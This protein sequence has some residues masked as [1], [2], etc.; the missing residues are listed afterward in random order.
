MKRLA[1]IILGLMIVSLAPVLCQVDPRDKAVLTYQQR[2]FDEAMRLIDKQIAD[3]P[4]DAGLYLNKAV[5][6]RL[7]A[8]QNNQANNPLGDKYFRQ[9]LDLL[10]KARHLNKNDKE[11]KDQINGNFATTYMD[12]GNPAK[13][14]EF[15]EIVYKSS[16]RAFYRIRTACCYAE[17]GA[18]EKAL[19]LIKP[20]T[21]EQIVKGDSRGNE[22][23]SLYNMACIYTLANNPKMAVF[24][25][26]FALQMNRDR[27]Y[28]GL[29]DEAD[30]AKI[31]NSP[32]FIELL[33]KYGKK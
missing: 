11:L 27:F 1:L 21:A 6:I 4:N 29:K 3:N 14:I 30:F 22:G 28:I 15:Y 5:M 31:R 12:M 25:L 9:T 20:L 24:W 8:R 18:I 2:K 7:K 33:K 10:I 32:E 17:Q 13:A 16:G 26:D 23:L 19:A